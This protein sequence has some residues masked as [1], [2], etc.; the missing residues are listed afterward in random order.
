MSNVQE[1]F[2][3][4]INVI[5]D[6]RR[7]YETTYNVLIK[8]I[9]KYVM[10]FQCESLVD[11]DAT[12]NVF[13]YRNMQGKNVE[14]RVTFRLDIYKNMND[15]EVEL[16]IP[17]SDMHV[18]KLTISSYYNIDISKV[19]LIEKE[20]DEYALNLLWIGRNNREKNPD[21]I[22]KIA[23]HLRNV[24]FTMNIAGRIERNLNMIGIIDDKTIKKLYQSCDAFCY[25]GIWP[26]PAGLTLLEA[27][28]FGKPIIAINRGAVSEYTI[29]G[30]RILIDINNIDIEENIVESFVRAVSLVEGNKDMLKYMGEKAKNFVN[31]N[32]TYRH[33]A[34]QYLR[35]YKEILQKIPA[36]QIPADQ[37][38]MDRLRILI[39]NEF[40]V[41]SGAEKIVDNIIKYLSK[42]GHITQSLTFDDL[43]GLPPTERVYV[44]I[45][46]HI[47]KAF[48]EEL[49][50]FNPDIVHFHNITGI[51][52]EPMLICKELDIPFIFTLHD[53]YIVCHNRT[54]YRWDEKR[55]CTAINWNEC[56]KCNDAISN[57]PSQ[58]KIFDILKDVP[59]VCISKCQME[60]IK[61][62]G[63]KP[64]NLR[65]IYNGIDIEEN[66]D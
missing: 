66:G 18:N 64:E 49:L 35:L 2:S 58:E 56:H 42:N 26:E 13:G 59:I 21:I 55:V 1:L 14:C 51:G 50:K 19:T 32:F 15:Y 47:S 22:I 12:I 29:E 17:F 31:N 41:C 36:D 38:P 61:R 27:Q 11:I 33:M 62:F 7:T 44:G 45:S 60:I 37:I 46:D 30:G 4:N 6:V 48:K 65:V 34:D 24:K 53:Y 9:H 57:L 54:Y 3:S 39:V 25:T 28:S 63:Y 20:K 43:S 10:K 16:D 8:S 23:E 52:I 40:K 5:D